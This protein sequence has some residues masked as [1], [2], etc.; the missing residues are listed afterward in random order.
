[1]SKK[2]THSNKYLKCEIFLIQTHT[3]SPDFSAGY[4]RCRIETDARTY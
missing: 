2:I 3:A 1:V 4:D